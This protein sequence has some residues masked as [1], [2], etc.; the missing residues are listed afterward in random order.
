MIFGNNLITHFVSL[1]S[2]RNRIKYKRASINSFNTHFLH[3]I[4]L[5]NKIVLKRDKYQWLYCTFFESYTNWDQIL[6]HA[7]N[8]QQLY[9]TFFIFA[10]ARNKHQRSNI[11]WNNSITYFLSPL[12][13]WNI[14]YY[15]WQLFNSIFAHLF[16]FKVTR[17]ES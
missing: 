10:A 2:I 15:K 5:R 14:S 6:M 16:S 13:T 17:N 1:I 9:Y 4:S 3:L 11:F 12:S 7:H 8:Y